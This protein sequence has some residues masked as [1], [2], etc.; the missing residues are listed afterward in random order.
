LWR[1]AKPPHKT[2]SY[3]FL[4]ERGKAAPQNLKP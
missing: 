2:L 4:V 1:E 3:N